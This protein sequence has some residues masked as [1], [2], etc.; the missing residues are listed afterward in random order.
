M[1]EIS[2][3]LK[4]LETMR[5]AVGGKSLGEHRNY[6]YAPNGSGNHKLWL[7]LVKKGLAQHERTGSEYFFVTR[8]GMSFLAS[9]EQLREDHCSYCK[10]LCRTE[11]MEVHVDPVK[12]KDEIFEDAFTNTLLCSD[13][14][15]LVELN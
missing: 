8:F 13:C 10:K 2:V 5:N 11:S 6:S 9:P 12:I 14:N 7:D 4:Q 1:E 3:T 15:E